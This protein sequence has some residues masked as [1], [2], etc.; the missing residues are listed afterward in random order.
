MGRGNIFQALGRLVIF[1]GAANLFR[2]ESA[3]L[4]KPHLPAAFLEIARRFPAKLF[5]A[6]FPCPLQPLPGN[7]LHA[8]TDEGII[9]APLPQFRMDFLRTGAFLKTG[10]NKG[11]GKATVAQQAI[12]DQRS[13]RDF[14]NIGVEAAGYQFF[15][16]LL[17]T[18]F[19]PG[20]EIHRP[21]ADKNRIRRLLRLQLRAPRP[22]ILLP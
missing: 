1:K 3:L 4:Q 21:F 17:L 10:I 15:S 11:L 18:M 7:G 22:C 16:N 8:H 12:G 19:A 9:D 14:D 20:K 2:G 13:D 6:H 5:L